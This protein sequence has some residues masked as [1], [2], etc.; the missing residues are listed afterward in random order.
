M[1]TVKQV[2]RERW[3]GRLDATADVVARDGLFWRQRLCRDPDEALESHEHRVLRGGES[4]G[5]GLEVRMFMGCQGTSSA[6]RA[7]GAF[8]KAGGAGWEVRQGEGERKELECLPRVARRH[9]RVET[10]E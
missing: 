3:T 9:G 10:W 1:K 5:Q 4:Q 2:K 6:M 7:P 8:R